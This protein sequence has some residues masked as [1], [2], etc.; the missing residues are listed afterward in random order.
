[1]LD[2]VFRK[3]IL[4]NGDEENTYLQ[5]QADLKVDD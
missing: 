4:G 1:M 2:R 5:Q 3:D